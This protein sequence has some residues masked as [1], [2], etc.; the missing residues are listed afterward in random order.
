VTRARSSLLGLLIAAAATTLAQAGLPGRIETLIRAS[1]L[2]GATIAVSVREAGS[3]LG[4]ALVDLDAD[5][6]MIPASNMKL[7]TSGAALHTLGPSFRFETKL[8]RSGASLIVAGDGDPAFGDPMLLELMTSAD[9]AGLDV[10]GFVALWVEAVVAAE[11]RDVDEIVVDDR[12]FDREYVHPTWPVDQLNRDY[13]AQVS[14][15]TFHLNCA[16]FFPQPRPAERPSLALVSPRYSSLGITN[17]ATSAS[18]PN[19]HDTI[20]IARKPGTNALTFY[21]NVK[22]AYQTPV[23]VT[24]HEPAVLFAALLADRLRAAGV[25]VGA[26]RL[27]QADEPGAG[28]PAPGGA[29]W[30]AGGEDPSAGAPVGPIIFTPIETVVTRCN[31][32]SANLY[33]ECLIKRA[34]HAVTGQPGTW[35][36]GAAIVRHVVHERLGGG[37]LATRLRA[38]DGS[39]LSRHN[40]VAPATL[41]AWLD[42]FQADERLGRVFIDSLAIGGASGTLRNRFAPADLGG[43]VVHAKSGVINGVSCLS[44]YVTAPDGRRRCFSVMINDLS[45]PGWKARRLQEQVVREIALDMAVAV[46]AAPPR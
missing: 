10:E 13:C 8:L 3:G 22:H 19:D 29:A 44:G 6:L 23:D 15:L 14:G 39:G 24:V 2:D 26:T 9:G 42:S 40:R 43:A 25:R 27:V 35:L 46:G 11:I 18:G 5:R 7:L 1:D 36:G 30:P 45:A 20:W 28:P 34:A 12:V 31:R 32:D 16:H 41:T 4:P 38:V 33:A 21:G 17:N 37:E